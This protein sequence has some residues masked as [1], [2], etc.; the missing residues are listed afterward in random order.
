MRWQVQSLC[1]PVPEH[2]QLIRY[3]L[4]LST[5]TN[6]T[7]MCTFLFK[8]IFIIISSVYRTM[9]KTKMT[10]QRTWAEHC[11][12]SYSLLEAGSLPALHWCFWLM[13]KS[14]LLVEACWG[15]EIWSRKAS[16]SQIHSSDQMIQALHYIQLWIT[17]SFYLLGPCLNINPFGFQLL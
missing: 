5:F 3:L 1:N 17:V 6:Y 4:W 9:L 15:N 2:H 12:H 16:Q 8:S 10:M 7:F 14:T 11:A 13:Y